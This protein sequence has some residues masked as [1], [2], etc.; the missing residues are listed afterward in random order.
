MHV[1]TCAP[2]AACAGVSARTRCLQ[3]CCS[4]PCVPGPAAR[5]GQ[6]LAGAPRALV[7]QGPR[8]CGGRKLRAA[9]WARG[10]LELDKASRPPLLP[11]QGI[12]SEEPRPRGAG[13]GAACFSAAVPAPQVGSG[14]GSEVR[15]WWVSATRSAWGWAWMLAR[16]RSCASCTE[17]FSHGLGLCMLRTWADE[18]TRVRMHA[19]VGAYLCS[20]ACLHTGPHVCPRRLPVVARRRQRVRARAGRGRRVCWAARTHMS[21]VALTCSRARLASPAASARRAPASRR[22]RGMTHGLAEEAVTQSWIPAAPHPLA[23]HRSHVEPAGP[24]PRPARRD[25][26]GCWGSPSGCWEQG[27]GHMPLPW[28]A[29]GTAGSLCGHGA[30]GAFGRVG[31]GSPGRSGWHCARPDSRLSWAPGS[32]SGTFPG[33]VSGG[34]GC[35]QPW[36]N[37]ACRPPRQ[38]CQTL[39]RAPT[40]EGSPLRGGHL[41][42]RYLWVHAVGDAPGAGIARPAAQAPAAPRPVPAPRQGICLPLTH[43]FP[44][45]TCQ[46]PWAR[47]GGLQA[48]VQHRHQMW[49]GWGRSTC[50]G[51]ATG[52]GCGSSSTCPWR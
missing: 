40:R 28:A 23:G 15:A 13:E 50:H 22:C 51:F 32:G 31:G 39:P 52:L 4:R 9:A 3:L 18:C 30:P 42:S 20:R 38:R 24:R 29:V 37:P 35:T 2:T 5:G 33:G 45:P 1:H 48:P 25:A 14:P 12:W 7:V 16:Q 10:E 34:A 36:P 19:C 44:G 6:T 47:G 41:R 26:A 11:P 46:G 21:G 49:Q 8:V 27:W 17:G 43:S